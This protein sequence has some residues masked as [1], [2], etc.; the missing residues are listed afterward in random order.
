MRVFKGDNPAAQLESRQKKGDYFCWWCPL[1]T[2]SS[3]NIVQIM[4]LPN[5]F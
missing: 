4:S 3:P 2:K 5:F 1:F